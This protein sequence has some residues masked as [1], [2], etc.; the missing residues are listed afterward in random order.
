[1][2][3]KFYYSDGDIYE[4]SVFITSI[5]KTLHRLDGYAI[6]QYNDNNCLI[7][8]WYY[9]YGEYVGCDLNDIEYI[10]KIKTKILKQKV[11]E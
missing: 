10:N 2:K 4:Y 11:F 5:Y 6:E 3:Y 8:G 7:R 1:M 9:I